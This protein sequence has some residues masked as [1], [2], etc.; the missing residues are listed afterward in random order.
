MALDKKRSARQEQ[1]MDSCSDHVTEGATSG[2]SDRDESLRAC[3]KD[4][5]QSVGEGC[6][7]CFACELQDA[8][9]QETACARAADTGLVRV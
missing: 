7:T 1:A 3:V 9:K 2:T 8:E 4:V 5:D 6:S